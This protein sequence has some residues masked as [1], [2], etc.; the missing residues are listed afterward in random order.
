M[1]YHSFILDIL[2]TAFCSILWYSLATV[3][4]W[5]FIVLSLQPAYLYLYLDISLH[6]P[7]CCYRL[8]R[9]SL[10]VCYSLYCSTHILSI[11]IESHKVTHPAG[12]LKLNRQLLYWPLRTLVKGRKDNVAKQ[13]APRPFVQGQ[14]GGLVTSRIRAGEG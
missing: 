14:S 2:Q 12:A 1:V 13:S 11:S 8:T 6:M 9:C 3:I 7:G 10:A 5:L 4:C